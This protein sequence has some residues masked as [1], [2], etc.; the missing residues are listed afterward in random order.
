MKPGDMVMVRERTTLYPIEGISLE[1]TH[2]HR[3]GLIVSEED[4]G[5]AA[6]F[7]FCAVLVGGR[8]VSIRDDALIL[9]ERVQ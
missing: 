6:A 2:A 5:K 8:V 9:L 7:G 1:V 3:L 4:V